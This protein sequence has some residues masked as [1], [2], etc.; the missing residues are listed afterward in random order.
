MEKTMFLLVA[1]QFLGIGDYAETTEK[2][3]CVCHTSLSYTP[4]DDRKLGMFMDS[5]RDRMSA[6][7]E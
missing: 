2:N 7:T 3:P 6:A 1:R 4:V 5:W